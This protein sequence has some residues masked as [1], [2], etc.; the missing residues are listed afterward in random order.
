MELINSIKP[1]I[2]HFLDA[3]AVVSSSIRKTKLPNLL[4]TWRFCSLDKTLD[5]SS[6]TESWRLQ[7]RTFTSSSSNS[8]RYKTDFFFSLTFESIILKEDS[9][10]EI[11]TVEAEVA[12]YLDNMYKYHTVRGKLISKVA[13]YP[14]VVRRIVFQFIHI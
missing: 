12:S 10:N 14:H 13:K 4:K 8:L 2:V 1:Y 7:S 9:L 6:H 11:R 5:P 3:T